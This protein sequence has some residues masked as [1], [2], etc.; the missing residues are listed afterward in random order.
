MNP[1]HIFLFFG[2]PVKAY[3]LVAALG[4]YS[5]LVDPNKQSFAGITA[6]FTVFTMMR[7]RMI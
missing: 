3:Q 1:H 6:G 2:L 5:L 4:A 7:M